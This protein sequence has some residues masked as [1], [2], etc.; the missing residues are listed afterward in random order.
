MYDAPGGGGVIDAAGGQLDEFGT[1]A[2]ILYP[3]PPLQ[4]R[5]NILLLPA[6]AATKVAVFP[7]KAP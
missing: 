1:P 3:P 7:E 4:T 5:P 6:A 2:F